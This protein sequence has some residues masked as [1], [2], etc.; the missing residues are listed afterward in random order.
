MLETV[1]AVSYLAASRV[2]HRYAAYR[3]L[4]LQVYAEPDVSASLLG[5]QW[6]V[7]ALLGVLNSHFLASTRNPDTFRQLLRVVRHWAKRRGLY[8]AKKGF[9]GGFHWACL[10][11][12]VRDGCCK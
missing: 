11:A 10:T 2:H 6:S 12:R 3:T 5:D 7:Q 4:L 8:G 9:L 1:G